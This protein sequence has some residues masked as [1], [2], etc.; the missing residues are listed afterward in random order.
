MEEALEEMSIAHGN[1]ELGEKADLK[2]HLALASATQNL[3]LVKLLNDVSDL[4][5]ETMKETRRIWIYSKQTTIEQLYEEHLAIY[6]AVEEQD[7]EKA[8]M[9]MKMH[10][11]NVEE[12]IKKYF[13]EKKIVDK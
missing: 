3:L 9:S 7:G 8:G 4:M 10:L 13:D 1:E 12:V 6:R 5:Q 11:N 2:F